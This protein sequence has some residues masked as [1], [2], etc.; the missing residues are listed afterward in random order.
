MRKIFA[1]TL[2]PL[3]CLAATKLPPSAQA[4]EKD[5]TKTKAVISQQDKEVKKLN[6]SIEDAA[7]DILNEQKNMKNLD[8]QIA[9]LEDDVL[10][11]SKE[12]EIKMKQIAEYEAQ[13]NLLINE[14]S[15]IEKKLVEF[16]TKDLAASVVIA[17]N[18]PNG[19]DDIVK[20]QVS[21]NL[22]KVVS[23]RVKQLKAE[24]V[25]RQQM[26]REL[27]AK[28]K[29]IK[30][31]VLALEQKKVQLAKTKQ[32][33]LKVI[34]KIKA[35]AENYKKKLSIIASEQQKARETLE[36]L[37]I[38]KR[39]KLVEAQQKKPAP[40]PVQK[41]SQKPA[42]P[43]VQPNSDALP[44]SESDLNV[45]DVRMLGSSYQPAK[46]VHY[47]G[48]KVPAPLEDFKIIKH[49]GPYIDP[50]YKIRIHNDSIQMRSNQPDV[51]VKNIL[52]GKIVFAK[53]VASLGNVVIVQHD[54]NL[55]SIYA[56]L[57][58]I[59]P[60][61]TAGKKIPQGFV[62]GRTN[63]DLTFEI[64]KEEVPINPLEVIEVK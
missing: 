49:F 8:I 30:M 47:A 13:K 18:T 23:E 55:H 61:I 56:H 59:A 36:K 27:E 4:V 24:F 11:L 10:K 50:I 16:M 39:Q 42:Q 17:E 45:D 60:T 26:I 44:I 37:N 15:E 51:M 21:K 28:V 54:G 1:I 19:Q 12:F 64:T 43:I 33:K 6:N 2:L 3:V 35:Q 63:K 9:A 52:D 38:L 7:N 41:P 53:E 5:I 62:V 31:S 32:D 46:A 34:E 25:Q 29:A 58:K 20:A 57:T 22:S 48:K 40:V 14:K